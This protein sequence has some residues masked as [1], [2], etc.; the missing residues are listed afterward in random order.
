MAISPILIPELTTQVLVRTRLDKPP[1]AKSQKCNYP[2][3]NETHRPAWDEYHIGCQPS[4][5]QLARI[6]VGASA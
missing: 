6:F 2:S 3:L 1:Q 4:R 5:L